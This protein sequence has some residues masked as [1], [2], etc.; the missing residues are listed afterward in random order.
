M[1]SKADGPDYAILESL[2]NS[3]E[4]E[5]LSYISV[6]GR[7]KLKE[8]RIGP[9]AIWQATSFGDNNLK[10]RIGMTAP[11]VAD[12]GAWPFVTPRRYDLLSFPQPSDM[13][14]KSSLLPSRI[15]PL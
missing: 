3:A 8:A 2:E 13:R 6:F 15:W 10:E 4:R 14:Y 11:A 7:Q 1:L 5:Y 12:E 9:L